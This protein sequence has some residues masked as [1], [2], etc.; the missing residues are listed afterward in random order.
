MQIRRKGKT[1]PKKI[2]EREKENINSEIRQKRKN[3]RK[4]N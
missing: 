2:R 3:Q 1:F 4:T